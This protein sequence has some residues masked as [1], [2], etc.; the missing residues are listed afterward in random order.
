MLSQPLDATNAASGETQGGSREL[1]LASCSSQG[2]GHQCL[3]GADRG[4]PAP[5]P[6]PN[7]L[8]DVAGLA[9]L[10]LDE[11]R[12]GSRLNAYLLAAGLNQI[13]ED[14]LHP[15]PF[16]LER[17]ARH[18]ARMPG[19]MAPLAAGTARW[20]GMIVSRVRSR[21]GRMLRLVHWQADLSAF[22][23]QL[24]DGV[25]RLTSSTTHDEKLLA[26]GNALLAPLGRF[27]PGLLRQVLRL[28]SCFRSFDQQ[29]AD[30]ERIVR[31]FAQ[32]WPDRRRPLLVVGVRTSGSYLAP[33]YAAFLKTHGYRDV[34]VL[35]MR[36]SRRLL[37]P[38]RTAVQ[39]VIRR[40]GLVL[41]T[42]DPPV[43]GGSLARTAAELERLGVPS[44][45]TILLLQLFGSRHTLPA[46]L[47]RYAAVLLPWEEW[48]IHAQLT[49][50]AV[51]AVL[52]NLLPPG[53][54]VSEIEPLPLPPRKSARS[55]G[56][57]LYC[58]QL[59]EW[60]SGRRWEERI[61]AEG[62]GLGYFGEHSLAVV[63]EL[64][65][66]LPKVYG[67]R[68]SLLYRAWLPEERM[69]H[70]IEPGEE[71]SLAAAVAEYVTA[72][73]RSLTLEEDVSLRLIGELPAW[74]AASNLLSQAF[75]RA[76]LLARVP[77]VDPLVK[78]LLRVEHPSVIDGSTAPSRWFAGEAP[79]RLL[80]VDFD[81]STFRGDVELTCYDP[82]FD[83][84]GLAA[85][86]DLA[87]L[88][89]GVPASRLARH[90]RE[91]YESLSSEPV[92]A[93]RWL[94]Y[95]LVHLWDLRRCQDGEQPEV[96]RAF[97]RA[98]Q[99]YFAEV[100]FEDVPSHA[101][102]ELCA[103]DNDGVLETCSLGFPSLTPA[104][105]ITLRALA[106]HGYR[107]VLV[108]GRSLDE[109]RERCY[110]YRMAG[111]VAEYG[112]VV[113]DHR[114]GRA[115]ELLCEAER[116][117][118]DRLRAVLGEIRG[119]Y[120]DRDFRHAVRAYRLDS[121]GQR[122]SLSPELV[123][124]A[125]ERSGARRWIR[126]IGGEAQT[127]FMAARIDKGIGLRILTDELGVGTRGMD[128][129][130]LA[131]AVGDTVS[132]LPMFELA[133]RAFAP[134]HAD[135]RVRGAGVERLERPYQAGLALAAS[136]LLG[137]PP[138]DCPTCRVPRLAPETRLLLT[139]LAAQ[140]SGRWGMLSSALLLGARVWQARLR[141]GGRA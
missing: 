84:A 140:E 88:A 60:D 2:G 119:V 127:D 125:L 7:L 23:Q 126:S 6:V 4:R 99:R 54:A 32:N 11:L 95:C 46:P 85:S 28:P 5:L 141:S 112:A 29:P 9:A 18:L 45:S 41:L 83:L 43:S 87:A 118:L 50:S 16:F 8:N 56:R 123:E 132:D 38:E 36:P 24:A 114:T 31:D 124:T 92:D 19:P 74:E 133:A 90:L 122:R 86:A 103:I 57:S 61:L 69:L 135:V 138:G 109:V 111:G 13:V 98:V 93:E 26:W 106:L 81:R 44:H 22:V 129:K 47:Q 120:V 136:R 79:G 27:P 3:P 65:D 25:A 137:H 71:Q 17:A 96:R 53:V 72:R 39:R 75:G 128:E 49:P 101:A 63:R 77:L 20:I 59:V 64:C 40:G 130:R 102:G 76:W 113:Y 121:A 15:D 107:P 62:V 51:Q 139:V 131:L 105:A 73:N 78:R 34:S 37:K 58:M 108:T 80:K 1:G 100:Y 67:L 66:F 116:A 70:P 55:H 48:A 21:Q 68:A 35:T 110:A 30:L 10:L 134:A 91:A 97:S 94:L 42:D 82:V 52:A 115:R 33:L 104:G 14:Y 12:R 89:K 117:H